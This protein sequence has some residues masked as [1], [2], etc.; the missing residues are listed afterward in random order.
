MP[1]HAPRNKNKGHGRAGAG[2]ISIYVAQVSNLLYRRASSLQLSTAL[3]NSNASRLEIGDTA[4]WKPALLM[5]RE[6]LK[7]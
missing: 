7:N 1:A 6:L 3:G 4:G 2:R 5:D